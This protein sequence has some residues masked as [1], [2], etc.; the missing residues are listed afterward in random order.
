M[1][2]QT[3]SLLKSGPKKT[4]VTPSIRNNCFAKSDFCASLKLGKFI[5]PDSKTGS[6]GRNFK[7]SGLGV[8]CVSINIVLLMKFDVKFVFLLLF[9]L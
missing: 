3:K 8:S 2:A 9:L 5:V 4:P 7:L 1:K 6:P